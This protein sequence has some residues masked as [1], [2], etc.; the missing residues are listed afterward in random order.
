MT[1]EQDDVAYEIARRAKVCVCYDGLGFFRDDKGCSRDVPIRQ[2]AVAGNGGSRHGIAL[3]LP[4]DGC[5]DPLFQCPWYEA[6]GIEGA[7]DEMIALREAGAR[8]L[9]RL[10][11][12]FAGQSN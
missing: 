10:A 4:C 11:K 2:K 6:A 8:T 5:A 7:R 12:Q 3:R 9:K 1:Q